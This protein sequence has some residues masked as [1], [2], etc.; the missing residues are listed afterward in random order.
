MNSCLTDAPR[1]FPRQLPNNPT[2]FDICRLLADVDDSQ[3]T[4]SECLPQRAPLQQHC[5]Q[6][7]LS[8][9]S[10]LYC[11]TFSSAVFSPFLSNQQQVTNLPNYLKAFPDIRKGILWSP[12]DSVDSD[13]TMISVGSY[14]STSISESPHSGSPA[15][16]CAVCGDISSGKH[17]GI[18]A[19]NG[20][21][22]FFK[23]SVRRRLIYRCQAGTGSCIV[24]KAHR[25]Q[26]QACRLKKCLSKGMNKDAVQNERQPRNTATIRPPPEIGFTASAMFLR[27]YGNGA[28]TTT[29]GM[30][31][32]MPDSTSGMAKDVSPP[33]ETE[34]GE[35]IEEKLREDRA[36][37][38]HP[39]K[40]TQFNCESIH[41]T[42]AK[43]LF[44]AI[45]WAKNLSSFGALTFR[46]QIILLG[47]SWCDLFLLSVF[48][49][50]LPMERCPLLSRSLQMPDPILRS[51]EDLFLRVR[52][53]NVTPGEFACLKALVLFRPETRGLKDVSQIE[54]LQD[55]TQ[56]MLARQSAHGSPIRFGRLLLTLPL[57]RKINADKVEKVFFEPTFRTTPI[58]AMIC[59]M[60]KG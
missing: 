24:D 47:E 29:L 22:G 17:Y 23:R 35:N 56:Q 57:L 25:N 12:P 19:C 9:S 59:E 3:S 7:F 36:P 45:K 13:P 60:Y 40:D 18:L 11:D 2:K 46:D 15:L 37:L 8:N 10:R 4:R 1:S 28:I 50:S 43:L 58:E 52:N 49:W 39:Q 30:S 54:E 16:S 53:H 42:A 48:Q 44:M 55:Q 14:S 31:G 27:E 33:A 20:C 26:C 38:D 32:Q 34:R 21:S 5:S 51:L 41:E 6:E